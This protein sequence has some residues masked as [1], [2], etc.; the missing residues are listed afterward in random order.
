MDSNKTEKSEEK[1]FS[2]ASYLIHIFV[3]TFIPSFLFLAVQPNYPPV[4]PS[5]IK[6][7]CF[8]EIRILSGAV[9]LYNMDY[10][11]KIHKLDEE[12]INILVDNKY[13]KKLPKPL[14]EKCK[15]LSQGDLASS[16]GTIYCEAHGSEDG[17]IKSKYSEDEIAKDIY[18]TVRDNKIK[19]FSIVFA[20]ALLI[21]VIAVTFSQIIYPRL[22][23]HIQNL[24]FFILLIIIFFV[25]RY[26]YF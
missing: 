26:L 16:T 6:D 2:L 10:E 25:V 3:F 4:R 17:Q 21:S 22:N 18:T 12:T 8:S 23:I 20:I 9:E 15:Y 11:T 14:I 7:N 1:S 24:L 13:L 19:G 5:R